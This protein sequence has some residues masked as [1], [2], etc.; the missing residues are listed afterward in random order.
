MSDFRDKRDS[1]LFVSHTPD[2][3][4]GSRFHRPLH[5]RHTG[6]GRYPEGRGRSLDGVVPVGSSS[7]PGML[8]KGLLFRGN[9]DL[10]Q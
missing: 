7:Q 4:V 9:G 3:K 8:C 6:E 1:G 2:M 10:G 5:N